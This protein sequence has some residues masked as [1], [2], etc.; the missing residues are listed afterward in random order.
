MA[1]YDEEKV[2]YIIALLMVDYK[3]AISYDRLRS[4]PIPEIFNLCDHIAKIKKAEKKGH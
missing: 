1:E 4:L 2:G 3:G